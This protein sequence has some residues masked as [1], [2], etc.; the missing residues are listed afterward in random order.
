MERGIVGQTFLSALVDA[1][2]QECPRHSGAA[3]VDAIDPV[4]TCRYLSIPVDTCRYPSA[5]PAGSVVPAVPGLEDEAEAED[6]D[7][8]TTTH[9]LPCSVRQGVGTK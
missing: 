3:F 7:E 8:N 6:E 4:A 2:R 5:V 9:Q 1:R